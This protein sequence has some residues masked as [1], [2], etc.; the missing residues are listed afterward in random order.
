[1]VI[2][3]YDG[4]FGYSK[5]IPENIRIIFMWLCQDIATLQKKW[6]FYQELFTKDNT[7]LLADLAPASFNVIFDSIRSDLIMSI[8]RIND[9]LE[10]CNNLNLSMETIIIKCDHIPGL[11]EKINKLRNECKEIKK[12][13]NKRVGHRDYNSVVYFK[14]NPLPSF[15]KE[16]IDSIL[17][18]FEE[19][20]NSI[21]Q[22]YANE[23]L[24]FH[25]MSKGGAKTLVY[26]LRMGKSHRLNAQKNEINIFQPF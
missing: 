22:Y 8:C 13:R 16:N 20:L 17:H 11:K 14:K 25:T 18:S 3:M 9:P 4:K 10:S 24:S 5:Q 2:K 1:M 7:E 23:E 26:W 15:R 19:I 12:L 6:D 21:L